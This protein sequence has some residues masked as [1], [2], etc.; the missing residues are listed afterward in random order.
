MSAKII[1]FPEWAVERLVDLPAAFPRQR[2]FYLGV[3]SYSAGP[4]YSWNTEYWVKRINRGRDWEVYC[5]TEET[6]RKR[7]LMDTCDPD[8][9]REYFDSV[10]FVISD[11]EWFEMGWAPRSSDNSAEIFDFYDGA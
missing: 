4:G 9:V 1:D 11:K 7:Q 8:E 10:N 5:T 3:H 2:V 6:G